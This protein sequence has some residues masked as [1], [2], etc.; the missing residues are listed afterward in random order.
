MIGIQPKT[1][2]QWE[3]RFPEIRAA[4]GAADVVRNPVEKALLKRAVGY[5]A[6]EITRQLNSKTGEFETVKIVEKQVMPSTTAQIFWLKNRCGYEW[7]EKS[8]DEKGGVVML[9]ELLD[10]EEG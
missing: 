3:K 8:S 5:T 10:G 6:T 2:R 7:E 1:L 9:P 4:V